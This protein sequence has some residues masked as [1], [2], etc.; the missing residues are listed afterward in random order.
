MAEIWDGFTEYVRLPGMPDN[1]LWFLILASPCSLPA[2]TTHLVTAHNYARA[3]EPHPFGCPGVDLPVGDGQG[4]ERAFTGH[5][6]PIDARFPIW[7]RSE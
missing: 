1:L 2:E 5:P 7:R 3:V 4:R 6:R